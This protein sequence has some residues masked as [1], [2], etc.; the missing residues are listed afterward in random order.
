M[1]TSSF[2]DLVNL[3]DLNLITNND[4]LA[5][6]AVKSGLF[7]QKSHP[8][9]TGDTQRFEE[10]DAELYSED[11]T[12][13]SDAAIFRTQIGYSIDAVI[14]RKGFNVEYSYEFMNYEKY[15]ALNKTTSAA[16]QAQANR[17]DL[18][19]QHRIAFAT[20]TSYVNKS[21]AT[22]STVVGDGL[23][24]A[25]TAHTLRG[26]SSTYRN[27]LANN[28]QYSTGA[29]ELM[30]QMWNEN[31]LNHFGE[32]MYRKADVI[33]STEDPTVCNSIMKDMMSMADVSAP[34]SGVENPYKGKYRHVTL[35]KVATTATGAPDTTKRYYWG[36]AATGD[37]GWQAYYAINEAPHRMPT[38]ESDS[39]DVRKDAYSVPFR[40][41]YSIGILSGRY[42]TISTGDGTA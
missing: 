21:G 32:K 11:K 16:L 30:E 24:L 13:N 42:F 36:L 40:I 22:V 25:S 7:I 4:Y 29:L 17:L 34:N 28:P 41:G 8:N 26:T 12:E 9:K 38:A 1:V 35:S 19:L 14:Q 5:N 6:E 18:D 37:M 39:I 10:F 20:A 23:A 31:C 27:R 15:D 3:I 33:W 2:N